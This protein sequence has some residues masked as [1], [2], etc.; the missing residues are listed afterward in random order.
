MKRKIL[1]MLVLMLVF[2]CAGPQTGDPWRGMSP[3]IYADKFWDKPEKII[4]EDT[5]T[6]SGKKIVWEMLQM[7]APVAWG[8]RF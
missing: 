5:M 1:L 4:P 2:A 8:L 6:R 7:A 3:A